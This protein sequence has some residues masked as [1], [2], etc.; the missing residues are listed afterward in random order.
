MASSAEPEVTENGFSLGSAN[1]TSAVFGIGPG[2]AY[3]IQPI[4]LSVSGTIAAT[5][6]DLSN[7]SNDSVYE[8]KFGLGFQ[9]IVGKE[10]W[11]SP[12]WGLGIAGEF[13]TGHQMKDKNNSALT[14]SGTSGALLFSATYN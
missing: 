9:G 6:V 12:E 13:V 1:G 4:N 14:W 3:Y 11:V 8:S 10:W 2:L 5:Q 7:S